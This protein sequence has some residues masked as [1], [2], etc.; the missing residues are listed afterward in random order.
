MRT[1]TIGLVVGDEE[2]AAMTVFVLSSCDAHEAVTSYIS[3]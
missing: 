2:D 3:I 1:T